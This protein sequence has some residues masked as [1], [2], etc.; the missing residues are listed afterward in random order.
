MTRERINTKRPARD[1][2]DRDSTV[3]DIV[4]PSPVRLISDLLKE[5]SSKVLAALGAALIGYMGF[6]LSPLR[7]LVYHTIWTENVDIIA[8]LSSERCREAEPISLRVFVVP[9][10]SIGVSEGVITVTY[11]E[12]DLRI[13]AG[14]RVMTVPKSETPFELPA[15]SEISFAGVR[16]GTSDVIVELK[17]QYGTYQTK[18][19]VTVEELQ[20]TG[21]PSRHNLSGQWRIRINEVN[22]I[23]EILDRGG[24]I[25]G[26][27]RLDDKQQGVIDGL[28]D[29]TRFEADFTR[30]AAPLKWV[31]KSIYSGSDTERAKKGASYLEISGTVTLHQAKEGGWQPVD[32]GNT[33]Y[34]VAAMMN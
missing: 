18:K 24:S 14:S 21:K 27:Y 31:V 33:F 1:L 25:S 3:V 32:R 5:Y 19:S 34:A 20:G 26:S 16:P 6:Y 22:G 29:G 8:L 11:S 15:G 7:D 17:T 12:A 10:S 4:N 28:R 30:G 23:M 2:P 13:T 9:Q